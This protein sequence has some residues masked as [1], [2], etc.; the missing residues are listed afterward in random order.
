MIRPI[1]RLLQELAPIA[2]GIA[3]AAPLGFWLKKEW[4]S[5][6]SFFSYGLLRRGKPLQVIREDRKGNRFL[7]NLK[8]GSWIL[9]NPDA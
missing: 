1:I 9:M 7:L 6:S 3:A 4:D 8:D 5:V 2:Q